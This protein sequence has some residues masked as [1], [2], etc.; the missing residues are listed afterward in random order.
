MQSDGEVTGKI[1]ALCLQV[2]LS[3]NEGVLTTGMLFQ[4][5]NT[6]HLSNRDIVLSTSSE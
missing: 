5:L 4:D 3:L 6:E 1:Q 2:S